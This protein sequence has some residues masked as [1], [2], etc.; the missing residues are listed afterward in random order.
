[1]SQFGSE[2]GSGT[3]AGVMVPSAAG[4]RAG[5]ARTRG[6]PTVARGSWT[7]DS[8]W[9]AAGRS[10]VGEARSIRRVPMRKLALAVTLVVASLGLVASASGAAVDPNT[11]QPV[12]PNATCHDAGQQIICDTFVE[13]SLV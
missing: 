3:R 5:P 10:R 1:M 6:F 8:I 12:P 13:D 7:L 9:A 11:L 2:R 4:A